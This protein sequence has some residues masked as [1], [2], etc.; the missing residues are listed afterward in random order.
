VVLG[1]IQVELILH[2]CK[3][4][5]SPTSRPPDNPLAYIPPRDSP[6]PGARC[7]LLLSGLPT[8]SQRWMPLPTSPV[9]SS[10]PAPSSRVALPRPPSS[11]PS[12]ALLYRSGGGFRRVLPCSR[13][14]RLRL[15]LSAIQESL[16]ITESKNTLEAGTKVEAKALLEEAAG[17]KA[18]F[19]K[20]F[21]PFDSPGNCTAGR[22]PT[23][24][25]PKDVHASIPL[26]TTPCLAR[27]DVVTVLPL[28]QICPGRSSSRSSK[29]QLA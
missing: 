29:V 17:E 12:P 7:R 27:L 13:R 2:A 5:R 22:R 28:L 8:S 15:R 1:L 23:R 24:V 16:R 20:L 25:G 19:L 14:R 3:V 11:R 6:L 10:R 26:P 18:R 4:D 21:P 9:P